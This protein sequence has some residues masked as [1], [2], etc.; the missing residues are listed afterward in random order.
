VF[1]VCNANHQTTE[2]VV[3]IPCIDNILHD[4]KA[5]ICRVSKKKEKGANRLQ[6]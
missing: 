5:E 4:A 2:A 6:H 1:V 3:L